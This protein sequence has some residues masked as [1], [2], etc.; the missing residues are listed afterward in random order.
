MLIGSAI[1][2]L[3]GRSEPL[4]QIFNGWL[5]IGLNLPGAGDQWRAAATCGLG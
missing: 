2:I 3:L 4:D 1:G 5:V